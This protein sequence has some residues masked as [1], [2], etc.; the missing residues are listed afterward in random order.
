M[1][2]RL[3]AGMF[4][5]Q[6][7]GNERSIDEQFEDADVD[8]AEEG[9]D[10]VVRFNDQKT[11][12]RFRAPGAVRED[13]LR[14]ETYIMEGL[15]DVVVF[16]ES[17]RGTREPEEWLRFLRICRERRILIRVISQGG[18]WFDVRK[19]PRDWKTLADDG[20]HNAYTSEETSERYRRTFRLGAAKGRPHGQCPFGMRRVFDELTGEFLRQELDTEVFETATGYRWSPAGVVQEM[21]G[22]AETGKSLLQLCRI[23]EE[24]GIPTPRLHRAMTS[25]RAEQL[26][27]WAETHWTLAT[28]R[29]LLT[30]EQM[31]G[32]RVHLDAVAKRDAWPPLVSK[33]QFWAVNNLI[34]DSGRLT[35]GTRAG[36]GSA[37]HLLSF[38]AHCHC[39]FPMAQSDMKGYPRYQCY[40]KGFGMCN[41]QR[42]VT[43]DVKHVSI[44]APLLDD[45]VTVWVLHYLTEPTTRERLEAVTVDQ[46][47]VA[48]AR[49]ELEELQ[50]EYAEWERRAMDRANKFV[51]LDMFERKAAELTPLIEDAERRTVWVGLPKDILEMC[52]PDAAKRWGRLDTAGKRRV[53]KHV[54]KELVVFPTPKAGPR[55]VPATKRVHIS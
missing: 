2:S 12:S 10:I 43:R 6:S 52:G 35:S 15:L 39:G 4:G 25:G 18:Q 21:Y 20:I 8:A 40:G 23:F 3:R 27:R 5:R 26:E 32:S 54:V 24:R 22:W 19:R 9:Y 55:A 7:H 34:R 11:A 41:G 13:W 28:M 1:K 46:E 31:I 50:G 45:Y 14:L 51:T 36:R 37:I 49:A 38:I 53:I 30:N 29:K 44:S 47:S 16:W 48:R 33:E 42:V 17:S